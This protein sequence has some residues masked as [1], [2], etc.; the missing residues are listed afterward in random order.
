MTSPGDWFPQGIRID[1]TAICRIERQ[2]RCV[3]DYELIAIAKGL[4]VSVGTLVGEQ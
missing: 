4:A 2:D 3:M 1:Q